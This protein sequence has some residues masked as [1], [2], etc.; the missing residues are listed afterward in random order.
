MNEIDNLKDKGRNLIDST[1]EFI[2]GVGDAIGAIRN[3]ISNPD[4]EIRTAVK[5]VKESAVA[6]GKTV[7]DMVSDSPVGRVPE[8]VSRTVSTVK[9]KAAD[10]ADEFLDRYDEHRNPPSPKTP[11]EEDGPLS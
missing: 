1:K 10:L 3:D 11:E 5:D 8:T 2:G 9:E 7:R 4:G 6:A